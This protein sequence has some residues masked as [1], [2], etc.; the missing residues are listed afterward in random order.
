MRGLGNVRPSNGGGSG[1]PGAP[2]PL[3]AFVPYKLAIAGLGFYL[4]LQGLID[5]RGEHATFL[6]LPLPGD[7][8][9]IGTLSIVAGLLAIAYSTVALRQGPREPREVL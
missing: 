7:P 8:K 6:G 3:W 9:T 2:L 4:I 5:L 1:E